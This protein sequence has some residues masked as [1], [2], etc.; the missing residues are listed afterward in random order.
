MLLSHD[1]TVWDRVLRADERFYGYFADRLEMPG[2]VL[3]IAER[4]D[5]PEFDLAFIGSVAEDKADATL[6]RIKRHFRAHGR[7]P[8][9]RLTPLSLPGDWP[10][11]LRRAGF[12]GNGRALPL[13]ARPRDVLAAHQSSHPDRAR[14]HPGRRRSLLG[15]PRRRLRHRARAPGVGPGACPPPP[16]GGG[17][18]FLPGLARRARGRRRDE[19][20]NRGRDH[21]P[22][23]R[24]HA[25]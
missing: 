9:I 25:P 17:T 6:S 7:T 1:K 12:H 2:A 4:P 23:R 20:A 3:F 14:R 18:H 15:H 21:A 24:R 13:P 5:A 11:I 16:C 22:V 8:R 19:H 10:E